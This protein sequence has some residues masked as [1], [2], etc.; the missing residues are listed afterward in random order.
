MSLM[1]ILSIVL[2]LIALVWAAI[3]FLRLRDFWMV[4]LATLFGL[5]AMRQSL[6]LYA[7]WHSW[8]L[9]FAGSAT[10]A[11]GLAVSVMALLAVAFLE[12]N[13]TDQRRINKALHATE[14]RAR[15]IADLVPGA[16]YRYKLTPDGNQSFEFVSRGIEELFGWPAE[17]VLKNF[18]LIW[19]RI[20]SEDVATV[21]ASIEVSARTLEPWN[22]E[23]RVRDKQGR[24][25]WL[26]GH[27]VPEAPLE[28][29]SI[30][31]NGVLT[32]ISTQKSTEHDLRQAQATLER[33]VAER[34]TSPQASNGALRA[35][36]ERRERFERELAASEERYRDLFENA[37]DMIQA[38]SPDGRFLYV[39]RAWKRMLGYSDDELAGMTAFD[40]I[41]E[42][43]RDHCQR[44]IQ[45]L[46]QGETIDR[47]EATFVAKDG[48]LI[49]VSG[50]I[51]CRV[52]EGRPQSTRGIFR[53]VTEQKRLQEV[54]RLVAVGLTEESS[55]R[56]FESLVEHLAK[57]TATEFAF[58]AEVSPDAPDSART[59]A[60]W[61]DGQVV[62]HADHVL[63]GP[64]WE[65]SIHGS[66]CCMSSGASA[67]FPEDV[68]L[69]ASGCDGYIAAP[70]FDSENRTIGVVGVLGRK[71]V[72]NPE[73]SAGILQLLAAR[74]SSELL[75]KRHEEAIEEDARIAA[76]RADVGASVV[77]AGGRTTMLRRCAEAM[78]HRLDLAFV[79]IWIRD[80]A[81]DELT[82]Q[83]SAG[84][85]DQCAE[86]H[87]RVP[88]ERIEIAPIARRG[89]PYW[90]NSVDTDALAN[91]REW[92]ER[93][94]I[95]A[96]AGYPLLSEGRVLGVMALCARRALSQEV[97]KAI[98]TV[99]TTI[100]LA[101]ERS[102]VAESLRT[103]NEQ[104]VAINSLARDLTLARTEEEVRSLVTDMLVRDFSALFARL[105]VVRPGDLCHECHMVRHC[106]DRTACLHLVASSGAYTDVNG[107]RR[108][109]PLRYLKIGSI[110][111]G[112]EAVFVDRIAD[113]DWVPEKQ[114]VREQGL[115]SFAGFP[116]HIA[117]EVAGVVAFFSREALGA[118]A[119]E[120]LDLLS[121]LVGPALERKRSE[122]DLLAARDSAE[123]ASRAKSAFLANM[124]H[125]LR[126]PLNAILGFSD[127]LLMGHDGP[128]NDAQRTN[129]ETVVDSGRH[130]LGIVSNLLDLAR[131]EAGQEKPRTEWFELAEVLA[132]CVKTTRARA[133]ERGIAISSDFR[134]AGMAYADP[135]MVRQIV[136][137][138][139]SNACKFTPSSGEIGV[140]AQ[141]SEDVV[142]VTVW[143]TGIGIAEGDRARIFGAFEQV[144]T[145]FTRRFDG[146]GLGLSIVRELVDLHGGRVEVDSQPEQGSRFSFT[147]PLLAQEPEPSSATVPAS[148]QSTAPPERDRKSVLIIEDQEPNRKL[149]RSVLDIAGFRVFEAET[150]AAGIAQAMLHS[151]DAIL[152][153]IQLPDID[154]ISV[155]KTLRENATTARIPVIAITAYAMKADRERF[156]AAGCVGYLSKPIDVSTFAAEI[157]RFANW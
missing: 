5:M 113:S 29:G 128:L 145:S 68:M 54:V 16:V 78:A 14:A 92:A 8:E 127:L 97:F 110:A 143:D 28:D 44:I 12:R 86:T 122:R 109:M 105:W 49:E 66:S 55:E 106:K 21:R 53:D 10:E 30:I 149:I 32:D 27:A 139:L 104:L 108:R 1:L 116:F 24:V 40:V 35:E 142:T 130:L 138:L 47:V 141:R 52:E 152:L 79:G 95:A 19:D 84:S 137:N 99:A 153:D 37:S 15:H 65:A 38:I 11:P 93:E 102:R 96:F 13:I 133:A 18:D 45:R 57:I 3:L 31:W 144:E 39:N 112:D 114:W 41:H 64:P 34:T 56:F 60:V 71:P 17:Q 73:F 33:R 85:N 132:S 4:F 101:I 103:L 77:Q 117:G 155:L 148:D 151:P 76:T 26:R 75:R 131:I 22:K 42:R 51:N 135:R 91:A 59:I 82:L 23:F 88:V 98:G 83:A 150:G 63:S 146:T 87:S 72:A 124:S 36:I 58:V 20:L 67:D 154:G 119:K 100:V 107:T 46:F 156:L 90:T 74:A 6:T 136:D 129:L 61:S 62:E 123:A 157:M 25:K 115:R 118:T 147:L 126:T 94:R 134:D 43:S 50:D 7:T 70:L 89:E 111:I 121:R 140:R 69:A 2:R 48:T 9:T 120:S 81:D 125:E 80:D